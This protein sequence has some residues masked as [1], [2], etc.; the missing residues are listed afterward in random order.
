LLVA[1]AFWLHRQSAS[2][3][4]RTRAWDTVTRFLGALTAVAA[5]LFGLLQFLEQRDHEL[6]QRR[7][8]LDRADYQAAQSVYAGTISAALAIVALD[9]L[10]TP[11]ARAAV[12]KFDSYR[13]GELIPYLDSETE[14]QMA[15][16]RDQV[17][18]W[19]DTRSKPANLITWVESLSRTL[20]EEQKARRSGL[21]SLR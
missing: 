7:L 18:Q 3:E 6:R 19:R 2:F 15:K 20:A 1:F 9:S 11:A 14:S 8:E 5:G 17:S 10:N 12:M 21:D 13:Y 4:E 16:F